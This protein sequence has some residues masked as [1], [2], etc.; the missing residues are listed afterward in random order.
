M[1]ATFSIEQVNISWVEKKI[2]DKMNL[3]FS[4][5]YKISVSWINFRTSKPI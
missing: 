4:K 3:H 5:P 2:G 1:L